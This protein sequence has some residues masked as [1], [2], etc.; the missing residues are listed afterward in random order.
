M[1]RK[2]AKSRSRKKSTGRAAG[3]TAAELRAFAKPRGRGRAN[4]RTVPLL[5]PS[6]RGFPLPGEG[7]AAWYDGKA[8]RPTKRRPKGLRGKA[9]ARRAAVA[10]EAGTATA[11][12]RRLG[13][14][15]ARLRKV[16]A[17]TAALG[18]AQ[19]KALPAGAARGGKAPRRL[20]AGKR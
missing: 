8:R 5:N 6:A 18:R 9:L 11:L 14:L 3:L 16:E 17:T 19:R 2:S 12:R 4:P 20:P 1:K 15:D 13:E 10:R 7:G